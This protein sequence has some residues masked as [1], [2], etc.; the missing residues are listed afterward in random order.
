MVFG[1]VG[2]PNCTFAGFLSL[3]ATCGTAFAQ[4]NPCH[5]TQPVSTLGAVADPQATIVYDPNQGVCWLANANLAADPA[6]QAT[7]GISGINPNGS[8]DFA[9]AQK[10]VA[11]LNAFGNGA[12]YLGHNNWQ[13]PVAAMVD[14]TCAD[15]GT[16]GG[17]FGP[18]CT[19]SAL[20]NLYSA[21]LNLLFPGSVAPI[22]GATVGPIQN[23]KESYYWAAQN[24]GG[25]SGTNNG[26]Q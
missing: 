3:I 6:M 13:L 24:N 10:W 1:S 15:T 9:A 25:T 8:M 12:G 17:S 11:A 14:K 18:Q 5:T 22:S 26:G 4:N 7:L 19:A 2:R 16:F 23:M 20:G 21:G